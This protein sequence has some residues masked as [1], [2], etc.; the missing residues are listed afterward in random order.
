M[1]FACNVE[2][3]LLGQPWRWRRSGGDDL[4]VP[5]VDQLLLAR[6]VDITVAVESEFNVRELAEGARRAGVTAQAIIEV[7]SGMHRCGTAEPPETVALARLLEEEG[8][9]YR[10]IMGYEGHLMREAEAILVQD[11][12]PI[13]PIYF[14]VVSG[15]VHPRVEGIHWELELPDGTKAYN[16]QDIHPL[17]GVS[18]REP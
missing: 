18:I 7:D 1:S 8:V 9:R 14:Y 4:A 16:L 13:M 17:R 10:G 11:A 12:F 15:L 2:R 6:G 5:L 3:S